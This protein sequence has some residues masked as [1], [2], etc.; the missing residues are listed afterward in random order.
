MSIELTSK[1]LAE[2]N[3]GFNTPNAVVELELDG[4][5]VRFGSHGRNALPAIQQ[6]ADGA[7]AADGSIFAVGSDSLEPFGVKPALKSVSSLQNKL[8]PKN[9]FSTRG[10]LSVVIAGRENFRGLVR[11]E[12][13]KNRRVLRRDGFLAPGFTFLDYARTFAGVITDWSRRGD[14][15][16]LTV[17]DDLVDAS[18]KIPIE[19]STNTQYIDYTDTNPVDAMADMLTTRLGID[20]SNVNSQEFSTE[21]DLWLNNWRFSRVLTEPREA[22]Q[23]LNEL[24]VETNSFIVHDGGKISFKVYSPP[25]P[26]Q[27]V[28]EWTDTYDILDGTFGQK[29][30][31]REGFYNRVVVYYDY[32]ESGSDKEDNFE[33]VVISVDAASQDA[34]EWNETSTRTVKSRWIRTIT[35]TQP[36]NITG[37]VVYHASRNNGAGP[38][39]LAFT[40]EAGGGHTLTWTPPGGV[41]GDAVKVTKDGKFQVFG[42]DNTKWIRA[43]VDN[44]ALPSA[45]KSDQVTISSIGG[46]LFASAL[47]DKLLSRYRDPVSTVSF[48]VDVKN[49]AFDSRFIKPTDLKDITTDEAFEKGQDGWT[50]RRVML[51]S[52]RP[53]LSSSVVK[54]EAIEARMY[55]RYGFIAPAGHPDYTGATEEEREYGFIGD[56]NNRLGTVDG[57]YL[58]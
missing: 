32:D 37:V 14:E 15:L 38:G 22:N 54:V 45:D 4:G 11:D 17:S 20:A 16:H 2:L 48:E 39:T 42:A 5:A 25:I 56:L 50:R 55:R 30:G 6:K 10:Q 28:E 53:D 40:H 7:Y 47:A 52:V 33:S 46:K 36:V 49:V 34:S 29:S 9:G 35:F 3:M 43:V 12:Y 44:G 51:T 58:W 8:D 1:Y 41:S 13:L 23:Y 24:Q 31:Y 27:T 19:N 26:G 21:R 18:K 57:Y